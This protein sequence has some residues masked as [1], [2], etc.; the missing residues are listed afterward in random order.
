[1]DKSNKKG[2]NNYLGIILKTIFLGLV[3]ILVYVVMFMG[4]IKVELGNDSLQ[5]SSLLCED[6]T[7]N[8]EDIENITYEN[9]IDVG[10]RNWGIGSF[11]LQVGDFEN[12]R[13]GKYKL[14]S[15]SKSKDYVV[16]QTKT[17]YVVLNDKTIEKTKLLYSEIIDK[18]K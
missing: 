4:T 6:I 11:K 18:I 3:F 5:A 2:N 13:F 8:Y 14:Y 15:Y 9:D 10:N 1:M 17:T 12:D 7:I 16:I